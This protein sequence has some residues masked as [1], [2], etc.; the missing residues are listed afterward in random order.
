MPEYSEPIGFL[1]SVV[2]RKKGLLFRGLLADSHLT[3][4][5]FVVLN[6]L[7]KEDGLPLIELAKRAY[8][9]PTALSRTLHTMEVAGWLTRE[10]DSMDR[11][12][13]HL[14]LTQQG[15]DKREE[16]LPLVSSFTSKPVERLCS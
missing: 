4:Q 8:A 2:Y 12:V 6:T 3:P 10:Q 11:R 5:Q 16:L 7:G 15:K 13:F 9:D 1:L 14:H